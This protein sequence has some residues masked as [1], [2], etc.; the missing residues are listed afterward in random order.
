MCKNSQIRIVKS[1]A[2]I[3]LSKFFFSLS[4]HL[5]ET[6]KLGFYCSEENF[7]PKHNSYF[8]K[9]SSGT[10]TSLDPHFCIHEGPSDA[11]FTNL[12]CTFITLVLFL[13]VANNSG[14]KKI[15]SQYDTIFLL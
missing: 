13:F 3:F 12:F 5:K 4:K 8:Y 9:L 7:Y 14:V 11:I 10:E 6:Q 1:L 2:N 15:T